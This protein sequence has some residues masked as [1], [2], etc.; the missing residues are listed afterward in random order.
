MF[1]L[2]VFRKVTHICPVSI[3]KFYVDKLN[4]KREDLWQRPKKK[5]LLEDPTCYDDAPVGLNNM[6]KTLSVKAELSEVYANH[7][8]RA[9]A[10]TKLDHNNKQT[11]VTSLKPVSR[12][13]P[14]F[15]L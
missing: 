1:S 2:P 11:P 3:F 10:V 14:K 9:T 13:I 15:V 6:M 4:E 12:H 7:S 8:I 5:V